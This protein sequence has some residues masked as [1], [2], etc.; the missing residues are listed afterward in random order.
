MTL[1]GNE[2]SH[3]GDCDEASGR[4]ASGRIEIGT[5]R[6]S[7]NANRLNWSGLD[8]EPNEEINKER[9]LKEL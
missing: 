4:Q 6:Y 8:F 5:C 2:N 1:P 9:N 7:T 3:L